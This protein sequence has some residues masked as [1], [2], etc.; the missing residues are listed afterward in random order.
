MAA[1]AQD[2]IDVLRSIDGH[3]QRM[4]AMLTQIMNAIPKQTLVANDAD[5][6]SQWGDPIVRAKDP[7]DWSKESQ[8]GKPFSECPPEYLDLV[9]ARLDYFAERAE[10][11]GT[12]TSTGKPVAPYNRRD[13]ARARGWAARL[14]NGWK[15]PEQSETGFP[16]DANWTDTDDV[17][18]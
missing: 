17:A 15:A 12:L 18:F 1:S 11:E 3:L 16:S 4:A 8:I 6:D 7:R 9:A 13:A 10:A 2:V 14:R 5:L